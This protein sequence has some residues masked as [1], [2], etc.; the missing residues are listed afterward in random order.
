MNPDC[1]VVRKGRLL[2][3]RRDPRKTASGKR[4]R[5][6]FMGTGIVIM[7]IFFIAHGEMQPIL[8][9]VGFIGLLVS[10][11]VFLEIYATND[12][13]VYEGGILTAGHTIRDAFRQR[14]VSFGSILRIEAFAEDRVISVASEDRKGRPTTV[15][16]WRTDVDRDFDKLVQIL[17]ERTVVAII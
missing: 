4:L 8:T 10:T 7:S 1:D 2:Y 5:F 16:L 11:A 13:R 12:L 9:V 15:T 3:S 14:F 17:K 6:S